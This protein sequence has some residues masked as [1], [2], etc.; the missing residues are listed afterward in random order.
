[1]PL[2]WKIFLLC[3]VLAISVTV[4]SNVVL[5]EK[6]TTPTKALLISI[7]IA[8]LLSLALSKILARAVLRPLK[9]FTKAA[10]KVKS[11]DLSFQITIPQTDELGELAYAFNRMIDDLKEKR[12]QLIQQST[13]DF[14]TG[15][16][17]HRGFQQ[18]LKSE[19]ER[20]ERYAHRICLMTMD[21][22]RFKTINDTLGHP[23]GDSI[24]YQL[25]SVLK[26]NIRG[27]DIAARCG[28][29]EFA[30]LLPETDTE[31]AQ[32]VAERIRRQV[33]SHAFYAVPLE[34]L[35]SG[36]FIPDEKKIIHPT[37]TI[38][39]ACY[40]T[41]DTTLQGLVMAADI[42]LSRAK[43]LG[44]NCVCTYSAATNGTESE[45]K[46]SIY[47]MLR[48]RKMLA[49]QPASSSADSGRYAPS[50]AERVTAYAAAIGKA[51][52]IDQETM[53]GLKVAGMLHDLGKIG[54]PT[55]ILNKPGSLTFEERETVRRHPIIASNILSRMPEMER[56]SAAILSHH[57]RWDGEGY[58]NGLKGESIPVMARILAIA[59]A[60]DAMTSDRPYRK[61][62]SVQDALIEL[63]ANSG[64]Q[65]DPYMVEA[66][67]KS[68]WSQS[69]KPASAEATS[70]QTTTAALEPIVIT[71]MVKLKR[72]ESG[73]GQTAESAQ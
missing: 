18:R 49:V 7:G 2:S 45:N 43:R 28:G 61:A 67:I 55:A 41:D 5:I 44:R 54:L 72:P 11:G 17:N 26:D 32:S 8:L 22:D 16:L 19:I 29:D 59:D 63:K 9:A 3:A 1:M 64:K 51:L 58:P 53:D 56:I 12:D 27:I 21:M 4:I 20:A 31:T 62:M 73:Q 15:L 37:V 24:L 36:D 66:C 39:L 13:R 38:G 34:R 42:S 57:E 6:S 35:K 69:Q 40:P 33:E 25:S 50:H 65:F 23:I 48:E 30:I 71:D 70:A 60:F 46:Q 68:V 14:L 47:K 52:G 10:Q